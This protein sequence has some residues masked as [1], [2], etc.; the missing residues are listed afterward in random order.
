MRAGSIERRILE[1]QRRIRE[2]R[3]QLAVLHEQIEAFADDAE[4]ARVRWLAA[5][6][7]LAE[8]ASA[9]A[10]RHLELARRQASTI[11]ADIDRCVADRDRYLQELPLAAPRA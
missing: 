1:L 9:E 2:G 11:Q 3:D 5:E 8:R 7:P 6:T 4:E 10:Q